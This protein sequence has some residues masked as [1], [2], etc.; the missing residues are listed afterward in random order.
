VK[1]LQHDPRRPLPSRVYARPALGRPL[2]ENRA[3]GRMRVL[4]TTRQGEH[5]ELPDT[6]MLPY[7][8]VTQ[9]RRHGVAPQAATLQKPCAGANRVGHAIASRR[10]RRDS[11]QDRGRPVR[12]DTR[13][14]ILSRTCANLV[15]EHSKD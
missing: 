11:V 1:V 6:V 5:I 15:P 12:G 4:A 3:A 7:T 8:R 2:L 9:D 13:Q 10:A 14:A